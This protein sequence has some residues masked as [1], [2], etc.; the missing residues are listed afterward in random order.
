MKGR[1]LSAKRQQPP[2]LAHWRLMYLQQTVAVV[3]VVAA[4]D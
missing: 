2:E 3:A 4:A 1:S